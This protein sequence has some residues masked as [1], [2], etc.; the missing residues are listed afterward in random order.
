MVGDQRGGV[1][2]AAQNFK[3]CKNFWTKNHQKYKFLFPA[4]SEKSNLS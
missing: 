1:N 2:F 4:F 3:F